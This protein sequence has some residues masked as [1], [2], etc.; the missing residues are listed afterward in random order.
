MLRRLRQSMECVL[1]TSLLFLSGEL[2]ADPAYSWLGFGDF[3]GQFEPCGCDPRTD[4]GGIQ[5][6]ASFIQRERALDPSISL[7]DLGNNIS[8]THPTGVNHGTRKADPDDTQDIK[9]RH[10]LEGLV[11]LNPAAMLPGKYELTRATWM[12]VEIKAMTASGR[13]GG[14][15]PWV[16]SNL[17]DNSGADWLRN[18]ARPFLRTNG[19]VIFGFTWDKSIAPIVLSANSIQCRKRLSILARNQEFRGLHKILLF[20]GPDDQLK[21]IMKLRL[22]DEILAN[23]VAPDSMKPDLPDRANEDRTLIRVRQGNIRVMQTQLGGQGVLR[24]GRALRTSAPSLESIIAGPADERWTT[25]VTRVSMPGV[26]GRRVSWLERDVLNPD[27]WPPFFK[28]YEELLRESS[29]RRAQSRLAGLTNSPFAGSQACKGC[30][31]SAYDSWI[32]SKHSNAFAVLVEKG[33]NHDSECVS[34]HVLG[35]TE[36]GGF[37]SQEASPSFMNVQCENCHGPRKDHARNPAIKPVWIPAGRKF[38]S[39]CTECH[40]PPHSPDF[41]YREYWRKIAHGL[42]N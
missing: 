29:T 5:R 22:F 16:L 7:L 21:S 3:R 25:D 2:R 13:A 37:V 41:S 10:I 33:K 27:V 39:I 32:K 12:G 30:H 14:P 15:I 31:S 42:D 20:N 9:D 17:K 1:F 18:T 19:M 40:H 23:N 26:T 11:R 8:P 36:R 4:L 28:S 38:D 6:L 34:C 35:A 24:G